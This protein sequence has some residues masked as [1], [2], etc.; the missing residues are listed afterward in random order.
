MN[1]EYKKL[2]VNSQEDDSQEG[3]SQESDSQERDSQEDEVN[4]E[5]KE[6][7]KEKTS[8]KGKDKC[9]T[10]G[11]SSKEKNIGCECVFC[12]DCLSE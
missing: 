1:K 2:V 9:Y 7:K 6:D 5:V 3:D 11:K 4:E 12:A 10:C 8:E